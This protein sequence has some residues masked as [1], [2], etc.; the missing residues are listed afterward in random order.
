M[1]GLDEIPNDEYYNVA[2]V[3]ELFDERID[4]GVATISTFEFKKS[5]DPLYNMRMIMD[6]GYMFHIRDGKYVR[7][8]VNGQLMMSDTGMERISN[9][10][11]I[12]KANGRV[13]IAGLGIG[14]ILHNILNKADVTEV[15]VIEKYQDVID[16]VAPKFNNDKLKIICADIFDYTPAKDERFDVIYFDIWPEITTENLAEIRS[17]HARFK[18]KLNRQNQRHYM[19]S[20]M[21]EYLQSE[22]RK[23]NSSRWY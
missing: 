22:S 16:L 12:Q 23:E 19:N 13:L 5:H 15:I 21:K 1:F 8:H 3:T 2:G 7:L 11:F 9:K 20:W 4:K 6:G 18:Y 10:A 14:L 17:L